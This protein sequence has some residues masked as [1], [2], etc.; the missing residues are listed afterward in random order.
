MYGLTE[1]IGGHDG[2]M[3]DA[4]RDTPPARPETADPGLSGEAVAGV[5][6]LAASRERTVDDHMFR[7]GRTS[8]RLQL[9]TAPGQRAVV[10]VTQDLD[11]APSLTNTAESCAE[12]VW[13]QHC[14]DQG[15]PPVWIE[16]QFPGAFD[17]EPEFRLV[18]F[19]E[20]EPYQVHDPHWDAISAEQVVHLVG[21]PVA[22]DRGEGYVPPEPEVMP[23]EWFEAVG[24]WRLAQPSPFRKKCLSGGRPWWLRWVRL[25][26]PRHDERSCCW[27]HSGDWHRVNCLALDALSRARHEG[28]TAKDMARY[29]D[30]YAVAA[31]A[32]D[33]E[34]EAL[35]S[36]FRRSDALQP[37][38]SRYLSRG[39]ING[40]HRVQAMLDAGVRRTVVLR[41][42]WPDSPAD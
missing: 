9:F 41:V 23:E 21:G 6:R 30:K 29:A 42:T 18:T 10:V 20:T 2:G 40:Q 28:V 22:E 32:S 33:W 31:G 12:A 13:R 4:P 36:V 7:A 27:Y 8:F 25:A 38:G 37:S 1:A 19:G 39:Y 34:R 24:L 35:F 11:E 5:L 17:G 26:F 3:N 16:R 14:P 15:L